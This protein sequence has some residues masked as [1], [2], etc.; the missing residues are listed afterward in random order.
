MAAYS[1]KVKQDIARWRDSG[2][3]DAATAAVLA[4]DVEQHERRSLSFGSILAMLAAI[5][6]AA[7][8]LI[9]VAANWEGIP[10]LV[11]VVMLFSSIAAGYIGGALLKQ[12]GHDAFAEALWLIGAAAFGGS[13][14]LVS[15]MYHMSGDETAAILTWCI[16]TILAAAA[17][18][19][20]VL[21]AAAAA[22]AVAWLFFKGVDFWRVTDFPHAFILLA[23]VVWAVSYWTDGRVARHLLLLS[24]IGYVALLAEHYQVLPVALALT[25]VSAILFAVAIWQ[26]EEVERAVRLDARLPIH[27]LIGFLVGI[28]MIEI[29]VMNDNP[30]Q[31]LLAA[32][33]AFAGIAAALVLGG[34]ESR[35][36]RWIA[37]LGFAFQL[38]FVYG[39]TLGTMLGTA[40]FFLAAALILGIL[41][42]VI[43]R[44]E[45]R[46]RSEPQ[47]EGAA[48]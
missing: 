2:F 7:A 40:G 38:C 30:G 3:I 32:A 29:E 28:T 35:G 36:L 6:F 4:K 20:G 31:L 19:S 17:L 13:I 10:R 43:I 9:F 46:L 45:K 25:A 48:A 34:R 24:L 15:Q 8:I 33:F 23:F 47:A 27:A 41:A 12:R 5:L 18:R 14:A 42:F 26:S 1:V 11:R 21:T 22:L 39:V 37:Y 44:I 16:G